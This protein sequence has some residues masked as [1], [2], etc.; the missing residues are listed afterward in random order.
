MAR[1]RRTTRE[2]RPLT[3]LGLT[4][5]S[6][7]TT[8]MH[9]IYSLQNVGMYEG[10]CKDEENVYNERLVRALVSVLVRA[11]RAGLIRR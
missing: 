6:Q 5:L 1:A 9:I 7:K 3:S 2:S 11:Q 8:E 10:R 4:R